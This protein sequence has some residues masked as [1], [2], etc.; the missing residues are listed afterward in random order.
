[1]P[2]P[3]FQDYRDLVDAMFRDVSRRQ[4]VEIVL[5]PAE[6]SRLAQNLRGLTLT[7]AGKILT[8]AMVEDGK[9]SVE[10]LALV[11]EA[12]KSIVEREGL[13]EYFPLAAEPI[14]IAG[15]HGMKHWLQQRGAILAQPDRAAAFG[16]SFPKGILLLGVPGCGKSLCAKAVAQEWRLPLLKLDPAHLYDK[17]VGESERNFKRALSTAARCAPVV[18]WIDELEKAFSAH[19]DQD[20]GT[21]KRIF[22][23][24]LSWM[25]ERQEPV[26]LVATA[27]DVE[28]LPPEFLRK[29]RFDEIFFVDLPSPEV[30]EAILRIHLRKRGQDPKAFDLPALVRRSEGFSGA[31]LEQCIVAALFASFAAQTPLTTA[32]VLSEIDATRPLAVTMREK[33]EALRAWATPRVRRAD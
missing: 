18:L 3:S 16:L 24:F 31:E 13:L 27:N 7:E 2:A 11:I 30:R 1:M 19:G 4:H 14:E 32:A 6:L 10:D 8:R 29:G 23:S 17:Y 33:I 25:Q 21:G 28:K 22:G 15:L 20:G 12:K 5:G 26:F 9:L